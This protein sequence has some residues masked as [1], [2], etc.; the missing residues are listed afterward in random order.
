MV[1]EDEEDAE[2]G[3]PPDYVGCMHCGE[4]VPV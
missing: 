2:S 4:M 1:W 3:L